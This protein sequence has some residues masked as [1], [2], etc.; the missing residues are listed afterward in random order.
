MN[1]NG[2][3]ILLTG[4]AGGIGKELTTLLARRG[5]R[6]GLVN[7]SDAAVACLQRLVE[8]QQMDAIV[9]QADITC[10]TARQHAVQRMQ[11]A[12]GGIDV[13]INLAGTLDFKLFSEVD[14]ATIPRL[15]QVN[16][17]APM[18]L[19]REILPGMLARGSGQIVN[20]G[21]M[22]G[23]IGF[24]G[25][26]TYSASKFALRG[27]SQALRRELANSP[28]TVTYVS[29]RAVKTPFNPK[30]VHTMAARGMMHM[31]EASW[32]AARIVKAIEKD[33]DEVYLGFPESLFARING[34]LPRLIDR[35]LK[36]SLPSLS[37]FAR[38][39]S[40]DSP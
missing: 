25:F 12:F 13:L 28:I 21:S 1:L 14:A 11:H 9:I 19:I 33:R 23:S 16:L 32:V 5:A 22:F 8:N 36:K 26:A 30:A 27:F 37:A 15:L 10:A 24:P 38:D 2:K 40:P 4:A 7:H 35:S 17:E 31:D 20:I 6:L 29:P 39:A 18:Q 3:R 34:I